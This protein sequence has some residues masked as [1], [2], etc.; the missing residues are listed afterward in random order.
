MKR[1]PGYPST[2]EKLPKM[3]EIDELPAEV[4]ERLQRFYRAKSRW[5]GKGGKRKL[6]CLCH[7][8]DGTVKRCAAHRY[9]PMPLPDDVLAGIFDESLVPR[10]A[11][12]D[13][14][15]ERFLETR[16]VEALPIEALMTERLSVH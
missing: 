14:R 7:K 4:V 12:Y 1:Y 3:S 2:R 6:G 9:L 8:P 15:E 16:E 11:V 5:A 13:R 10:W